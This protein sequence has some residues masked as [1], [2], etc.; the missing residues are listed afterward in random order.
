MKKILNNYDKDIVY[1]L[2][3]NERNII[4]KDIPELDF[5]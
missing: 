1:I 4:I 3:Q 2:K 5:L